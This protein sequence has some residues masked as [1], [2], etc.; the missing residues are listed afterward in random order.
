M[1]GIIG[2]LIGPLLGLVRAVIGP[3]LA[4]YKGRA[5]GRAAEVSRETAVVIK[6]EEQA[7]EVKITVAGADAAELERLRNK[8][9]R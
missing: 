6:T 3:L 8:Y 1:G 5:D 7:N 2:V 4:Y 9:T